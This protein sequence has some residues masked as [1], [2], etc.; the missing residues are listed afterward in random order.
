MTKNKNHRL[1]IEVVAK[2]HDSSIIAVFCGINQDNSICVNWQKRFMWKNRF[3]F[4]RVSKGCPGD[5]QNSRFVL[6]PSMR[7]GL[8]VALIEAMASGLAVV[9]SKVRGDTD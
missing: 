4:F 5:I 1:I 6:F 8:P 7:E 3:D 2:L 9:C